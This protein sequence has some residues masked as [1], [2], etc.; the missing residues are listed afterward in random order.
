[1]ALYA[2][3]QDHVLELR[4]SGRLDGVT[5]PAAETEAKRWLEGRSLVL[6]D[7]SELEFI[8]S[9][10]LRLLVGITKNIKSAGGNLI[11]F[12]ARDMVREVLLI[13]GI[14]AVAP[15]VASRA[16]ALALAQS[17]TADH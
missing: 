11:L 17:L 8:T 13:S 12:G 3:P 5:S 9:A 4:F 1:M 2:D 15:S 7:L 14:D 6:A 10:G 16:D